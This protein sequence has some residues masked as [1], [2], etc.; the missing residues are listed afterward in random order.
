MARVSMKTAILAVT[1]CSTMIT[2]YQWGSCDMAHKDNNFYREEEGVGFQ[3]RVAQSFKGSLNKNTAKFKEIECVINGEESQKCRREGKEVYMPFSFL[4]HYFEVYGSIESYD[5]YDRFEFQHS[6]SKVYPIPEEYSPGGVFM[7]FEFYNVEDRNRVKCLT[8]QYGVPLSTQWTHEGHYYPIQIAQFGLSHYSKHLS[9]PHPTVQ[10]LEN[11]ESGDTSSW[12]LPDRKSQLVIKTDESY[13]DNSLVEFDTS[14]SLKNPG[15]TISMDEKKLTTL[16]LDVKFINNGSL[17]VLLRTGDGNLFRIHYIIGDTIINIQKREM[18][19]GLG[20]QVQGQWLHITRIIMNDF[21]KGLHLIMTKGKVAK[22]KKNARIAALCLRGH[23]FI[24]N[25]TLSTAAH[26]DHFF[27]AANYLV[28]KQDEKGGWPIMVQRKLGLSVLDAGWYS[29]MGQGQAISLLVRAFIVSKDQKY[30]DAAERGLDIFEI[31]SS[32]GGVVTKFA[33][34]Y[35]WYEEYPT[36]P[37]SFVLNGFI[38]SLLGIY[39]VKEVSK[40][41]SATKAK[42]LFDNGMNSL[43]KMLLMFDSGTGTFYDLRHLTLGIAPNRAR[44][45]YHTVHINQ[46]NL[47]SLI[48]NDPLFSSTAQRW[49]DY[50]KGKRS[51]HN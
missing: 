31:T 12:L 51:P 2:F 40:G 34:V 3:P 41:N 36:T 5:G 19:I 32:E 16:S 33:G 1:A 44:W 48:D 13:I 8:G 42:M 49:T 50:M 26:L 38:Y 28:N 20:S 39:D 29:A 17:T 15:I 10:I 23:G 21:T 7:S 37:A 6:Y 25:V 22:F 27:D 47:L 9:D 18:F 14:E 43:K 35:D 46:L 24:D 4:Q 11:G 30:L 45:D